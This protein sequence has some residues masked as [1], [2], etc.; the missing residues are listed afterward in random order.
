MNEMQSD[1]VAHLHRGGPYAY[2]W[3][4]S[5]RQSRYFTTNQK[6]PEAV[7][8]DVYMSVH[9]VMCRRPPAERGRIEDVAAINCLF[10][11]FDA[12][13]YGSKDE[14]RAHLETVAALWPSI[15]VDSG[16]GWHC[17][18]LLEQ[19][20]HLSDSG[21]RKEAARLQAQFVRAVGGDVG[22]KDLAR[23]L[24]LPGTQNAK[25]DPPRSVT[26]LEDHRAGAIYTLDELR[27]WVRILHMDDGETQPA[28]ASKAIA[29][30]RKASAGVVPEGVAGILVTL[31]SQGEGN[32]NNMLYWGAHRLLEQAIPHADAEALLLPIALAIGLSDGEAARTISSAYGVRASGCVGG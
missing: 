22:A 31:A 1:F 26:V 7:S 29:L 32:R 12:K 6:L 28:Q 8:A 5:D 24:R 23:V 14:V 4:L 13:D 11:E 18:W 30:A 10:A 9:P 15:I 3:R 16:G 20:L 17:Y 27:E 25:Y 2:L 19:P 21:D